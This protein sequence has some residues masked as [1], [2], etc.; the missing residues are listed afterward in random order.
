MADVITVK[1][2]EMNKV[3][4]EFQT[5]S[6]TVKEIT[7]SLNEALMVLKNG[8]WIAPSATAFYRTLDEDVLP[9]IERLMASL[10]QASQT[11][12][13]I[14]ATMQSGEQSAAGLLPN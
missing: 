10:A 3:S 1:Y 4:G 6:A 11:V 14:N 13:T 5:H 2:D 12:S 9:G 8:G 7:Q